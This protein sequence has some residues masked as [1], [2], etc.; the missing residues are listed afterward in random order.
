MLF[1]FI[2]FPHQDSEGTGPGDGGIHLELVDPSTNPSL[3]SAESAHESTPSSQVVVLPSSVKSSNSC[4]SSNVPDTSV[5][6]SSGDVEGGHDQQSTSSGDDGDRTDSF[7][8]QEQ[9]KKNSDAS[10]RVLALSSKGTRAYT[11]SSINIKS[12]GCESQTP[13]NVDNDA[14]PNNDNDGVTCESEYNSVMRQ[15]SLSGSDPTTTPVE[16]SHPNTVPRQN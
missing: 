16:E 1:Y 5:A 10:S 12:L 9:P 4:S 11:D 2:R 15:Y 14:P 13:A 3:S 7:G 6:A 8:Q